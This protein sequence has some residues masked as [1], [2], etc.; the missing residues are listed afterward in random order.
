ML[1]NIYLVSFHIWNDQGKWLAEFHSLLSPEVCHLTFNWV[2]CQDD[3]RR[4]Q[5]VRQSSISLSVASKGPNSYLAQVTAWWLLLSLMGIKAC[6]SYILWPLLQKHQDQTSLG[7][8]LIFRWAE[9]SKPVSLSLIY[10][11]NSLLQSFYCG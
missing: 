10:Q 4:S 6:H 7:K 9:F 11:M 3:V 2:W 5:M 8:A 1:Q